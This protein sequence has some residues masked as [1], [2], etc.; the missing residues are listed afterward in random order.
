MFVYMQTESSP[1]LF[2]VGFY[3]PNGKW[4]PESDHSDRKKAAERTAW[5]NGSRPILKDKG[6]SMPEDTG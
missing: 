1:D 3:D 5:L 4:I 6:G 2:T